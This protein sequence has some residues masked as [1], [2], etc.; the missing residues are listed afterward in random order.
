MKS[1]IQQALDQASWLTSMLPIRLFGDPVLSTPCKPVTKSELSSGEA[2]QWAE[3][4]TKFL[5]AY[6]TKTGGGRGLAANQLGIPKQLVLV[7]LDTGPEFYLNPHL[8]SS[9]GEGVYP[10]SCISSAGLILGDVVRP[11]TIKLTY[12]TLE[13]TNKTVSPD[14]IHSRILLHELDHLKG[15]VCSD[16]YVPGTIRLTTGDKDEILKPELKRLK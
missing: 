7:W 15:I 13:G 1:P 9:D 4:M 3:Q 14:E 10:E 11:W 12:V 5:E 8:D 16:S 2:K 6:R